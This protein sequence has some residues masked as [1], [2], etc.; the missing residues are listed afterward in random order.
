MTSLLL[1]GSALSVSALQLSDEGAF[2]ALLTTLVKR[3]VPLTMF[4]RDTPVPVEDTETQSIINVSIA[5]ESAPVNMWAYRD[6]QPVTYNRLAMSK[7]AAKYSPTIYADFPISNTDLFSGYLNKAGLYDRGDQVVEGTVTA[8]GKVTLT[9][10]PDSFMLTGSFAFTVKQATKYLV[11]VVP[12]TGLTAFDV[13]RDMT[14]TA[15]DKLVANVN[16]LNG[17]T[18]PRPI[19]TS[20]VKFGAPSILD[21]YDGINTEVEMLSNNSEVF[22]GSVLLTY[23]RVNFSWLLNGEQMV[24]KGPSAV[25]TQLLLDRIRTK[26]GYTMNLDD[27]VVQPYDPV[28]KGTT[29]TLTVVVN[30]ASLR[31]V[32]EITIDYTA[33]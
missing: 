27:L 25:T 24:L 7:V 3:S 33:E 23:H 14:G 6:A 13:A 19:T 21:E 1:N 12:S 31:Y 32:G 2:Q 4:K 28:P 30:E 29:A 22:L 16:L 20:E 8:P 15:A 18:L 10:V 5:K 11:D 9:A 17:S 26:T